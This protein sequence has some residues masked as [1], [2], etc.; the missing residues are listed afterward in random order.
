MSTV[1]L[2]CAGMGL[3]ISVPRAS[4]SAGPAVSLLAAVG[5]RGVSPV[6]LMK[7][8]K[9]YFFLKGNVFQGIKKVSTL[10]NRCLEAIL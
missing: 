6:G 1:F 5:V 2:V 4:L 9:K 8:L 7:L 3:L 10:L